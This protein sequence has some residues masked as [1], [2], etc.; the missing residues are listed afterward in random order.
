MTP[1]SGKNRRPVHI[2]HM[3]PADLALI[4]VAAVFTVAAA[5]LVA[6][7]WQDLGVDISGHGWMAYLI[8]GLATLAV[9]AGLFFLTF[10]SSRRGFDD[11]D[12]PED[13]PF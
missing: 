5:F 4:A 7:Q 1:E 10:R 2:I 11:I 8:G 3:K 12:R 6:G 13:G 9:S